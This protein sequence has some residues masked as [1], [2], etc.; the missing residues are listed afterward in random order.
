M[1]PSLIQD[2]LIFDL[3]YLVNPIVGSEDAWE[4][5]FDLL[6]LFTLESGRVL[7][8]RISNLNFSILILLLYNVFLKFL[9]FLVEGSELAMETREFVEVI[10]ITSIFFF[11]LLESFIKAFN[12]AP[13]FLDYLEH[14]WF[15]S[16]LLAWGQND[17]KRVFEPLLL[18]LRFLGVS[19]EFALVIEISLLFNKVFLE[20]KRVMSK[21]CWLRTALF[22]LVLAEVFLLL[23]FFFH[24]YFVYRIEQ[25]ATILQIVF[26]VVL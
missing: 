15:P 8:R 2:I 4:L 14:V 26:P 16:A 17:F 5:V 12:E 6:F 13:E 7:N 20:F 23:F 10:C 9:L 19:L 21:T 3:D 24:N 1:L 22:G 25:R 11:A 18:L